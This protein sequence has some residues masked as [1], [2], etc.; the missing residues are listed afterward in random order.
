V[1]GALAEHRRELGAA[2]PA[3]GAAPSAS[4]IQ[5]F[6]RE[7]ERSFIP[8]KSS[9]LLIGSL[10]MNKRAGVT[11]HQDDMVGRGKSFCMCF[12]T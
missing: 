6:V 4:R 3:S 8:L 7:Y 12:S 5:A 10:V 1:D 11:V 9:T 2:P